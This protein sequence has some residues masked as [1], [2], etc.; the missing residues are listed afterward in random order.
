MEGR[1]TPASCLHVGS[2]N[3]AL[4]RRVAL[5]LY[6]FYFWIL[7]CKGQSTVTWMKCE[8]TRGMQLF[9]TTYSL[10]DRNL[11]SVAASECIFFT[12]P[13]LVFV[14]VCFYIISAD[15]LTNSS[16][17][18]WHQMSTWYSQN[19]R[20]VY[21]R[22]G[23]QYVCDTSAQERIA[24]LSS[25]R[26]PWQL[27][28]SKPTCQLVGIHTWHGWVHCCS[29]DRDDHLEWTIAVRGGWEY[30]RCLCNFFTVLCPC[31]TT[32]NLSGV[33]VGHFLCETGKYTIFPTRVYS[34]H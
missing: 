11:S 34:A 21:I 4:L 19:T 1:I 26:R 28:I 16:R 22:R 5:S 18:A 17:Q 6:G 25:R 24:P 33:F 3:L 2:M 14:W 10:T 15:R 12:S 27:K 9:R 32:W 23:P 29:T 8:P 30:D 7:F 13:D 31:I 20:I